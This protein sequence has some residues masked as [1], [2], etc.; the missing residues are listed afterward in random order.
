MSETFD[1]N[2]EKARKLRAEVTNPLKMA[3]FMGAKLPMA[4]F[5]GIRVRTLDAEQC[6]TT[7]RYG[8]MTTNPFKSTYFAVLAMAAEMST[9][10]LGLALVRAAPVPMSILVVG[11]E[12][13]FVKK[14]TG[15]TT[16]TCTD[17]PAIQ[18]AVKESLRTGEGVTVAAKTVGV[19]QA[20]D[21]VARF[22][23]TWSFKAKRAVHE[24]RPST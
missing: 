14:A 5:A 17:G 1:P 19:D 4:L 22:T 7:V 11:M 20:G 13:E 9:G 8:W 6:S 10:A 15:L 23:F 21:V 16:F 3:A 18:D 2:N 12:A 24:S